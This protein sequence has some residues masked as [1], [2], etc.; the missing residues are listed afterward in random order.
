MNEFLY[1]DKDVKKIAK[2]IL[3]FQV[4]LA[5]LNSSVFSNT[6]KGY[7]MADNDKMVLTKASLDQTKAAVAKA[8]STMAATKLAVAK[9]NST[10]STA[11]ALAKTTM[12][13]AK[14]AVT[15]ASSTMATASAL[16]KAKMSQQKANVMLGEIKKATA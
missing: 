11:S 7:D 13:T 12:A 15:K 3:D 5:T 8:N 14:A 16:A 4:K 9:A 10:R 6:N 1:I 2:F